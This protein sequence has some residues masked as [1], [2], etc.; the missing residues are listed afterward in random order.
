MQVKLKFNC[1]CINHINIMSQF[2]KDEMSVAIHG[3]LAIIIPENLPIK[4]VLKNRIIKIL[5][6]R[7]SKLKYIFHGEIFN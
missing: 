2:V 1:V 4:L 6:Y 3:Q 7:I 5:K